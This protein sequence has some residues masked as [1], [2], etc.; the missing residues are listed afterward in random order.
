M[1]IALRLERSPH[2][3]DMWRRAL[4]H[5]KSQLEYCY[6]TFFAGMARGAFGDAHCAA[7]EACG[8]SLDKQVYAECLYT[9]PQFRQRGYASALLEVLASLL[10]GYGFTGFFCY[11]ADLEAVGFW[12][13]R[14]GSRAAGAHDQF[15]ALSFDAL[16]D[17]TPGWLKK[18]PGLNFLAKRLL[19]PPVVHPMATATIREAR[20]LCKASKAGASPWFLDIT[21]PAV[22]I[23]KGGTIS[24][25]FAAQAV[26]DTDGT[27]DATDATDAT[28]SQAAGKVA[29]VKVSY[30]ERVARLNRLG[31]DFMCDTA[32]FAHADGVFDATLLTPAAQFR[33]EHVFFD[34]WDIWDAPMVEE[35][36]AELAK[37]AAALPPCRELSRYTLITAFWTGHLVWF[38]DKDTILV[39]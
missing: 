21:A 2:N 38:A 28:P 33:W 20:Y 6:L 5:P 15:L 18:L 11:P 27:T 13:K 24:I 16:L 35:N 30:D 1:L 12:Q 31:R 9:H 25:R 19:W 23:S 36:R 26:C 8:L 4:I 3:V 39:D 29:D 22:S 7:A 37:A 34:G 14:G 32:L 10:K 17:P